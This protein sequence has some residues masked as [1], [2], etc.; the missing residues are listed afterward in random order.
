MA[1]SS[2]YNLGSHKPN[3]VRRAIRAA[4][5]RP[6]HLPK[7]STNLKL[8]EQFFAKFTRWLRKAAQRTTEAVYDA[9]A[10]ILEPSQ[11]LCFTD[12][13]SK[14]AARSYLAAGLADN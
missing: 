2:S 8:I 14:R 10:P 5:A 3:A 7:Y 9:V 13:G 11:P 12:L 4:G 1:T 6:F